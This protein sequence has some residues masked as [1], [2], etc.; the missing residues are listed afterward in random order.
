L[1]FSSSIANSLSIS[2]SRGDF[3]IDFDY[4]NSGMGSLD[5]FFRIEPNDYIEDGSTF[6]SPFLLAYSNA[7]VYINGRLRTNAYRFDQQGTYVIEIKGV[8]E[9]YHTFTIEFINPNIDR[10]LLLLLPLAISMSLPLLAYGLRRRK[11]V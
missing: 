7:E 10:T 3:S 1:I 8:G 9:Y 4:R 5:Y 2:I 11:V 6:D